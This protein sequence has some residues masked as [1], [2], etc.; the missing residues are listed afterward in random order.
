MVKLVSPD[1]I[2]IGDIDIR[3]DIGDIS[4]LVA[5]IYARDR[6]GLRPIVSPLLVAEIKDDVYD[7]EVI[8]GKRRLIAANR[9][10]LKLVPIV[11]DSDKYE[12]LSWNSLEANQGRLN[13]NWY[14]VGKFF[15]KQNENGMTQEQIGER[16]NFT[17]LNSGLIDLSGNLPGI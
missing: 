1:K 17:Q 13:N 2:R 11:V 9:A 4:E 10:K 3:E 5:S 7:Y 6:D 8:D 12:V 14:E 15:S 16:V